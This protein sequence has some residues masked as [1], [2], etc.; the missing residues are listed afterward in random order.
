MFYPISQLFKYKS[1]SCNIPTSTLID[2][3]TFAPPPSLFQ[4][5]R[6]LERWEYHAWAWY[7]VTKSEYS[8]FPFLF[9]ISMYSTNEWIYC[10]FQKI[11]KTCRQSQ[12][13]N[14]TLLVAKWAQINI[15]KLIQ[16]HDLSTKLT[17]LNTRYYPKLSLKI[18]T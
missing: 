8:L 4:P 2:F 9:N 3:P 10:F 6:L 15:S 11:G 14:I 7:Q 5:P 13:V 12:M 17:D 1:S 18:G 16:S